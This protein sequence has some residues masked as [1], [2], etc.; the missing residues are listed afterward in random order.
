[1]VSTEVHYLLMLAYGPLYKLMRRGLRN[2]NHTAYNDRY[3]GK[4][5]YKILLV[6]RGSGGNHDNPAHRLRNHTLYDVPPIRF[7]FQVTQKDIR[8]PLMMAG[9]YRNM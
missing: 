9:Y 2:G 1:M 7:L 5:K 3:F 4:Y 8:S 6:C